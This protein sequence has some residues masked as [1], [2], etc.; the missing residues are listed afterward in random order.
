MD[1][2]ERTFQEKISCKSITHKQVFKRMC[3]SAGLIMTRNSQ[4]R[5]KYT[6]KFL[7][8]QVIN[9]AFLSYE[10]DSVFFSCT[11]LVFSI[12]TLIM[13]IIS[14]NLLVFVEMEVNPCIARSFA[15]SSYTRF[16]IYTPK[17]L[18]RCIINAM[19]TVL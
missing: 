15:L 11:Y 18:F 1:K 3:F 19:K 16:T 6:K 4:K 10:S 9:F 17:R 13:L 14:G 12:V 8:K 7:R 5:K 2:I